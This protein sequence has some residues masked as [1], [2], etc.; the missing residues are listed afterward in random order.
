MQGERAASSSSAGMSHEET[1]VSRPFIRYV[2]S[3]AKVQESGTDAGFYMNQ[4]FVPLSRALAKPVREWCGAN[5][6]S[7]TIGKE[8]PDDDPIEVYL[9]ALDKKDEFAALKKMLANVLAEIVANASASPPK[10][11]FAKK[12]DLFFDTLRNSADLRD[13]ILRIEGE[14]A[15]RNRAGTIGD[16]ALLIEA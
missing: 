4:D 3:V 5:L 13:F 9:L 2:Q 12:G 16:P 10:D 7:T 15:A 14:I 6:A 1:T 8:G 11:V